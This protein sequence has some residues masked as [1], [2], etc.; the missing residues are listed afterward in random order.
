MSLERVSERVSRGGDPN[1]PQTPRPL[2]S[3]EEFFEGNDVVGS[4][5]GNLPT[6][7]GPQELYKIFQ[8]ISK[9]P[10]VADIRVSIT[11]FDDPDW[12]YSDT[13]YIMTSASPEEVA[14]WFEEDF[15]PDETWDGFVD[16]QSYERYSIPTGFKAIGCW[17]D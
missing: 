3:I 4:I 2:L 14:S 13:V 6:E 12:P 1:D 8:A 17:W 15:A 9:R 7:P 10:D 11:A 16:G 5:G